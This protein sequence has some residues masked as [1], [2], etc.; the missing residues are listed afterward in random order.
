MP[1]SPATRSLQILVVEDH[2]DL[3]YS[4]KLYLGMLG[5]HVQL[6]SNRQEARI[7][8]ESG[9][10]DLLVL[11]LVLREDAGDAVLEVPSAFH[12]EVI[13][14]SAYADDSAE[15]RRL[16]PRLPA[17]RHLQKPFPCEEL[18]SAIEHSLTQTTSLPFSVS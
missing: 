11:D 7:Q 10:Y 4:L 17:L 12:G 13:T 9:K 18:E 2:A 8:L 6:A 3:C 15:L 5:H 16:A 14:M 1:R